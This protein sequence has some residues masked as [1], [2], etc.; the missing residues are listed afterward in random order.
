MRA[1]FPLLAHLISLAFTLQVRHPPY[2]FH[3]IM[4]SY[5]KVASN[6]NNLFQTPFKLLNKTNLGNNF[7]QN[8]I[9]HLAGFPL[10][11]KHP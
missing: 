8:V 11:S 7:L 9:F 2:P 1:T 10:P 4:R 5:E 3:I 6:K